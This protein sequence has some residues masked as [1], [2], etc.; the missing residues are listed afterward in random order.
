MPLLSDGELLDEESRSGM[1]GRLFSWG[2]GMF[3]G[4]DWGWIWGMG[5]MIDVYLLDC[6][7]V[8]CWVVI[9]WGL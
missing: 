3:W 4:M 9:P 2:K 5:W 7:V 6:Y 8:V 1:P